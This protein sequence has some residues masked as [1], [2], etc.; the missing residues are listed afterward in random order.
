MKKVTE[1]KLVFEK[2]VGE[3]IEVALSLKGDGFSE[4]YSLEDIKDDN[5]RFTR[6]IEAAACALRSEPWS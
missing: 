6:I 1:I 3:P 4:S 5:E 2:K